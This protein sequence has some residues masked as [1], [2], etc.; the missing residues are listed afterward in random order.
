[1]VFMREREHLAV[2]GLF[3]KVGKVCTH[4]KILYF[5]TGICT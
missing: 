1:M 3:K 2:E 4:N 5:C